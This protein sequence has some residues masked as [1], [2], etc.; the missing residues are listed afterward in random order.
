MKRATMKKAVWLVMLVL[1]CGLG[2]TIANDIDLPEEFEE[3]TENFEGYFD[4]E[5]DSDYDWQQEKQD[6]PEE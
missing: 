1:I 5:T 6:S 4:D 3:F 2:Y